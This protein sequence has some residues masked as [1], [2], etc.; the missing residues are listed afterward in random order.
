M[1]E[2]REGYAG[3]GREDFVC[4]REKC[5]GC[6]GGIR[7]SEDRDGNGMEWE[8]GIGARGWESKLGRRI[9]ICIGPS[10]DWRDFFFM[11]R[12]IVQN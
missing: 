4:E 11:I 10:T 1:R 2:E 8:W 5:G 9:F 6:G 3:T 12:S 7:K